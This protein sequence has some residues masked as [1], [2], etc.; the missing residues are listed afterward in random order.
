MA[1]AVRNGKIDTR[2]ARSRLPERREP[3]WATIS[4]GCAVGYRRGG[5]GGNWIARFRDATGKQHY[6][7]LGAADDARDPDG[8][9]VFSF[10]QAQERARAFFARAA[11]QIAGGVL[12]GANRATVATATDSYL[13]DYRRRGGKAVDRV[14]SVVRN[15]ILPALGEHRLD[16]LTRRQV[17]QWHERLAES[18]PRVRPKA[19][20]GVAFGTSDESDEGRRRRK[21]TAN[22]VLTVLKAVLNHALERRMV[23][24]GAPWGATRAFR[25]ADA[26]R[27]RYLSDEE[28]RRLVEALEPEFRPVVVAALVTGCRY[29]ELTRLLKEDFD[30]SARTLLIRKS[31]AFARRHVVL[32]D[33]GA[34]FFERQ[35][36]GQPGGSPILR[37]NDGRAWRASEQQRPL[38]A[39]WKE[40]GIEKVTFHGLRHTYASRLAM[41]GVSFAVIAAQLGHKDTRMVEKHYGHLAPNYIAETVRAAFTPLGIVLDDSQAAMAPSNYGR[42]AHHP[43][44]SI[45]PPE[46]HDN[47]D[48]PNQK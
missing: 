16:Q 4:Q 31:K 17:E 44:I 11:Q 19:G 10:A 46:L 15:H 5:K 3:Y 14:A 12:P 7:A 26:A 35:S 32:T 9:T 41:K 23:A 48:H 6:S 25:E 39:A 29:G 36:A 8:L 24:D 21:S 40:A 27:I 37:R 43:S 22:R 13:A 28:A 33:E 18:A 1:R 20:R 2:S 45:E 38:D 30:P 34:A 47:Q 42:A